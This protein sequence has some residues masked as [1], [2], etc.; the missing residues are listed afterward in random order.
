MQDPHAFVVGVACYII[1]QGKLLV[2]FDVEILLGFP[3][4]GVTLQGGPCPYEV[5][6]GD[7]PVSLDLRHGDPAQSLPLIGI[8]TG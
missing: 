2:V 4:H 5:A 8:R 1:E 6:Q 7:I 3:I